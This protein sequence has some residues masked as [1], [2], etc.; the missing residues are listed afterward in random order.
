MRPRTFAA[1]RLTGAAGIVATLALAFAAPAGASAF[2]DVT[3]DLGLG[4]DQRI[5][6]NV[7]NDYFAPPPAV[8]TALIRRCPSPADDYPVLL[9]LA[10]ASKRS[11]DD[12]LRLRLDYLSWSDI[13]FRLNI[14]PA[15]L[16]AG[17][18]R[19]PGPPYGKA[20]GY[21]KKHP[22]ERLVIRDRDLVG[23]AK[24]QVAAGRHRVSPH[25]LIAERNKGVTIEH[26]VA[27]KNRG[28]YPRAKAAKKKGKGPSKEHGGKPHGHG[29]D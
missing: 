29:A 8:A 12:I 5:F 26:F 21:W 4:D 28:K 10:R 11:P 6:L 7:T 18:D 14:S 24:L 19:D 22:R 17:I 15:V 1:R 2:Y 25:T 3:L 13:M 20:W 23:L 16:F 27:E 9:L